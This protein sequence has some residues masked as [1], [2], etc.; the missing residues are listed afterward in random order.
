MRLSRFEFRAMNTPFRRFILKHFEFST[1]VRFLRKNNIDLKGKVL[2][3][4]GCGSGYDTGLIAQK[5]APARLVAFDIMP[6]QIRLARR[7]GLNAEFFVGDMTHLELPD[8]MADA[9]FIF[10]VLHHIPAWRKALE[11]LWRILADGGVLLIGEPHERFRWS[12]LE[13]GIRDA[14]FEMVEWRRLYA[15]FF[16]NYLWRKGSPPQPGR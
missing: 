3:D 9:V 5:F 13:E 4:A 1:F 2:V 15:G 8:G 12:E 14:G 11:E 7:L 10:G 6:E 16:R